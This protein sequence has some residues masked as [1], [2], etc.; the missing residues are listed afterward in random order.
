MLPA[1]PDLLALAGDR[2]PDWYDEHG[3][4]RYARFHPDLLGVYDRFAVLAE[5]A[6]S[7]CGR[8]F[9]VGLGT[10]ATVFRCGELDTYTAVSWAQIGP[11]S[12]GD[13]P[14]HDHVDGSGRCAGETMSSDVIGVIEVWERDTGDW[15]CSRRA[16]GCD[17]TKPSGRSPVRHDYEV[18]G[19]DYGSL[20]DGG[21][22]EQLRCRRCGRIAF[23]PLAD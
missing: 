22:Y 21:S 14:R 8:R 13:P 15:R 12:Y 6:C 18:V 1:F 4:P 2:V 17:P 7:N 9:L 19:D 20:A 11:D 3:T 5:I 10:P 23:S 16:T